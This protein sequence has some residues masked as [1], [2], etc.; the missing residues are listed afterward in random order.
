M[1]AKITP[2]P[3]YGVP[4]RG[5][6]TIKNGPNYEDKDILDIR[7]VGK[8]TAEA[9]AQLIVAAPLLLEACKKFDELILCEYD[10]PVIQPELLRELKEAIKAAG[11]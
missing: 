11:Q 2:G 3:W 9:N 10:D 5:T 6:I 4:D 7:H 1:A 8:E